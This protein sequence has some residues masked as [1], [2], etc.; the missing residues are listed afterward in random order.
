MNHQTAY[1]KIC[2]E[3]GWVISYGEDEVLPWRVASEY[4]SGHY[5]ATMDEAS[6]FIYGVGYRTDAERYKDR[7][8]RGRPK[9]KKIEIWEV[10]EN[11]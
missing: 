3:A 4:G 10:N 6:D 11:E 2:T 7:A 9:K 5:F 8:R 1:R